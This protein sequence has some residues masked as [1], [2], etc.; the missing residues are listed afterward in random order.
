MGAPMQSRDRKCP[1]VHASVHG[2]V[3]AC[4]QGRATKVCAQRFV[5]NP[6]FPRCFWPFGAK[7]GDRTAQTFVHKGL[8]DNLPGKKLSQ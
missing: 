4:T 1:C 2:S 5:R 6:S 8:Y 7:S 3:L